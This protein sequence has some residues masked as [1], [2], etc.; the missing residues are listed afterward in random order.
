[1][2]RKGAMNY[3]VGSWGKVTLYQKKSIHKLNSQS[4]QIIQVAE[5]LSRVA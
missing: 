1:M 4:N 2:E 3:V 5:I